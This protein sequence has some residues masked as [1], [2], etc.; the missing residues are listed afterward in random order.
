MGGEGLGYQTGRYLIARV[1]QNSSD[2][3]YDVMLQPAV[4]GQGYEGAPAEREVV[5]DIMRCEEARQIKSV[6]CNGNSLEPIAASAPGYWYDSEGPWTVLKVACPSIS[7]DA[8]L[9]L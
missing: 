8:T 3:A 2:A 6:T 5:L 7:A 9:Q 4:E 1:T